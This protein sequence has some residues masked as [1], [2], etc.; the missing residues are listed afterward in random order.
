MKWKR[1]GRKKSDDVI[2][3]R[4][5]SPKGGS[6]GGGLGG[7]PIPTSMAGMG[8]TAGIIVLLVIVGISLFGGG[9][10]SG[11]DIGS[12]LGQ[13]A[14]PPG[15]V[16]APGRGRG[17]GSTRASTSVRHGQEGSAA[18]GSSVERALI[19]RAAAMGGA[20]N[21]DKLRLVGLVMELNR[22]VAVQEEFPCYHPTGNWTM[23][24]PESRASGWY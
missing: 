14:A 13:G 11:F 2:D 5:A 7:L 6:G 1:V 21:V 10:G 24:S 4:G 16:A 22:G 15:A 17:T 12:V 19:R 20:A 9:S 3:I 18:A 23:T 8:G